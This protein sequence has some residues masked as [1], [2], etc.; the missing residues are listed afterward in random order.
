MKQLLEQMKQIIAIKI[1]SI[2]IMIVLIVTFCTAGLTTLEALCISSIFLF[3][4]VVLSLSAIED[5]MQYKIIKEKHESWKRFKN[6]MTHLTP[7]QQKA[8]NDAL[9]ELFIKTDINL[10]DSMDKEENKNE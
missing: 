3:A 5:Y 4:A 1:L 6:G 2:V 10:F 7:E 8:Y 9:D